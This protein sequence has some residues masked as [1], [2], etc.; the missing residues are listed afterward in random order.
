MLPRK[1]MG[2]SWA[3]ELSTSEPDAEPGTVHYEQHT[4]V[5][6]QAHSLL[7]LKRDA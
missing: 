4:E 7:V 2:P 3:L 5:T 6:V 1:Y